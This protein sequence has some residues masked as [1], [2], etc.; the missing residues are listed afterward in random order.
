MLGCGVGRPKV[1]HKVIG[2]TWHHLSKEVTVTTWPCISLNQF[3]ISCEQSFLGA[4]NTV[5]NAEALT[6]HQTDRPFHSTGCHFSITT[7]RHRPPLVATKR[8]MSVHNVTQTRRPASFWCSLHQQ[9]RLHRVRIIIPHTLF[10]SAKYCDP[11]S[12]CEACDHLES[13]TIHTW[14]ERAAAVRTP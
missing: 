7:T 14:P 9:H 1:N 13:V 3:M 11:S 8:P 12:L 4:N 2:T 5:C 6:N 10:Q